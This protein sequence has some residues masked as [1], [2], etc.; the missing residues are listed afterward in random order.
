MANSG[1]GL[2]LRELK[3]RLEKLGLTRSTGIRVACKYLMKVVD[4]ERYWAWIAVDSLTRWGRKGYKVVFYVECESEGLV[5]KVV[6]ALVKALEELR[7]EGY[8]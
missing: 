4:G 8:A 6:E 5:V 7:R 3:D 2:S 1:G